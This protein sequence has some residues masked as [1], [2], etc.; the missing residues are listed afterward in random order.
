M[1]VSY[2]CTHRNRKKM[3]IIMVGVRILHICVSLTLENTSPH[4]YNG[5]GVKSKRGCCSVLVSFSINKNPEIFLQRDSYIFFL[6]IWKWTTVL[7][8]T[9]LIERWCWLLGTP[10]SLERPCQCPLHFL[11]VTRGT[12]AVLYQI[13]AGK[14]LGWISEWCSETFHFSPPPQRVYQVNLAIQHIGE[15]NAGS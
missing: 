12:N 1:F 6:T 7:G 14:L 15:I 13:T 9:A 4:S 3:W 2:W 8:M 10:Q 5:Y 11:L